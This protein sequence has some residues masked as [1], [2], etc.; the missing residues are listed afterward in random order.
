MGAAVLTPS[1]VFMSAFHAPRIAD[2]GV[3]ETRANA[4]TV[5]TNGVVDRGAVDR[6]DTFNSDN[7]GNTL[8]FVGLRYATPNRFDSIT[9]ELGNQFGDGG[10]WEAM[11]NVY[12]LKNQTLVGDTVEPNMSP[13][14]VQVAGATETTGHVFSPLVTPG[15]GGTIKLVIRLQSRPPTARAGAGPWA[16]SMVMP[17][18]G[19]V[20]NFISL[21]R[22]CRR[23]G[24]RCARHSR[25][26]AYSRAVNVI[27]NSHNSPGRNGDGRVRALARAR[28]G[29]DHQWGDRP[30][31]PAANWCRT[32]MIRFRAT[33]PARRPTLSGC[34]MRV[35]IGSTG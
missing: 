29:I 8:D 27:T 18:A 13:N 32:V 16:E 10:D 23:R 1:D 25:G 6:I 19:G 15:P 22:F 24:G 31:L 35:Y 17:N 7:M 3:P 14:W 2:A 21:P 9:I 30:D 11:P 20:I 4:F 12:I 34:N 26:I 33:A 5:L 28:Y